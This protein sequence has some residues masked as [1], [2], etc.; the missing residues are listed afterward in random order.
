MLAAAIFVESGFV[1]FCGVFGG[2][3]CHGAVLF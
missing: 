1:C 3:F 2:A